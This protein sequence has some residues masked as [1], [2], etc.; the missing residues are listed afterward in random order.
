MDNRWTASLCT[1]SLGCSPLMPPPSQEVGGAWASLPCKHTSKGMGMPLLVCRASKIYRNK[2]FQMRH[3][4]AAVIVCLSVCLQ[5]TSC[6]AVQIFMKILPQMYLWTRKSWLNFDSRP[7]LDLDPGIFLN[8][9]ST[10]RHRAF[11]HSLTSISGESDRILMQIL[12][13]M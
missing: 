9:P 5:A 7:L 3:L 12:P 13:Q 10:L 6:T 8:D 1:W 11:F 4:H 2:T